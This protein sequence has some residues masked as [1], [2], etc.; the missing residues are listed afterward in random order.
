MILRDEDFAYF[1]RRSVHVRMRNAL[2]PATK[3]VKGSSLWSEESLPPETLLYV[4]V[5]PR[6]LVEAK[7]AC[8]DFLDAMR[9]ARNYIQV[10]G[11]ETVGE[12]WLKILNE[13]YVLGST[14]VTG[15]SKEAA[16]AKS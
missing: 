6:S 13:S 7:S 8:D 5:T 4:V 10:G 9:H 11:N 12:G 15:T 2:D 1:C 16:D 3:T 14:A